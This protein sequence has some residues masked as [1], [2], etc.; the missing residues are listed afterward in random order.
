MFLTQL[1]TFEV[2]GD[3]HFSGSV[4]F[5]DIMMTELSIPGVDV[6]TDTNAYR[7]NCPYNL[8]VASLVLNLDQ[9][10]TSGDVTV[11]VTNSTTNHSDD[12]TFNHRH[13]LKC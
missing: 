10:T 9:H 13:R 12:N 7:F 5:P 4:S 6:Q 2:D 8:T 11:T 3:S 1:V